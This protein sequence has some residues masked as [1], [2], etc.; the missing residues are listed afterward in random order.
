MSEQHEIDG[1]LSH[2]EVF[3]A[4]L[5]APVRRIAKKIRGGRESATAGWGQRS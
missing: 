2:E 4:V 5:V 1:K 3:F